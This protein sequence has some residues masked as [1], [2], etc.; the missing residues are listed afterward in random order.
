MLTCYDSDLFIITVTD[1]DTAGCMQRLDDQ[2]VTS[3]GINDLFRSLQTT[4]STNRRPDRLSGCY[5][6]GRCSVARNAFGPTTCSR[7]LEQ[8]TAKD[9]RTAGDTLESWWVGCMNPH[10]MPRA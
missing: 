9:V 1:D 7:S 4:S 2:I 6:D 3:H 5:G 10:E 8:R